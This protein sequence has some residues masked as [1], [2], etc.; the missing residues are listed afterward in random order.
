[1]NLRPRLATFSLLLVLTVCFLSWPLQATDERAAAGP[2]AESLTAGNS[3][4]LPQAAQTGQDAGPQSPANETGPLFLVRKDGKYG[5]IDKT[6]KIVI[7]PQY[8]NAERFFEGLAA[9]KIGGKWGF[10][11]KTGTLVIPP[12]YNHTHAEHFSEGLAPVHIGRN[13]NYGYIDKTGKL[14]IPHKYHNEYADHFSEGLAPVHVGR[15]GNYGY[16]DKTGQMIFSLPRDY[17]PAWSPEPGL[18]DYYSWGSGLGLKNYATHSGFSEGLAAVFAG[19]IGKCGYIDKTGQM[20]MPLQ[21]DRANRF[22]EGLAAVM[23]SGMWGYIDKTG[24][25]VIPLRYSHAERFSEGLAAV[26]VSGKWGFID[27][28]GQMVIP[29]QYDVQQYGGVWVGGLLDM[30]KTANSHFSEGL[31][32]VRVGKKWGFIDRTGQMVIPPLYDHAGPFS[33]GLAY[34]KVG[35]KWGY[36]DKTGEYV[37]A[38]TK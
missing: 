36:I 15:N 31:A 13:G 25:T 18:Q 35:K 3:A 4:E 37:W 14:V 1:M 9:V 8:A 26:L 17:F 29:P 23:I 22:T 27:K 38:P 28:T 6:G 11:D 34:V 10:I 32:S 12:K 24:K 20:V 16:I 30:D 2:L 19:S 5:Y 7:P 33:E 21:Y